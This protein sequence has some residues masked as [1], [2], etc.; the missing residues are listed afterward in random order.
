MLKKLISYQNKT[1]IGAAF[2]LA[3]ASLLSRAFGLIR[4]RLLAGTFGASA[5][6]DI[7]Y[8]AFRLPDL[9]YNI[10]I[11]GA[12]SVSF[13]PLF[14][15]YFI[16]NKEAAWKYTVNLFNILFIALVGVSLILILFSTP[17][18]RLIA[19]GFSGDAFVTTVALSRVMFL[20]PL[21]LGLSA[22]AGGVLHYFKRFLIYSLA[23]ILYNIG[24]II[25]I[26]IFFPFFGL[27]GLAWG[28]VLG[29]LLHLLIQL[30][31]VRSCGFSWTSFI[32]F[33]DASIWK[34]FSM[35][36]PRTI[37]TASSQI[38]FWF[39]TAIA[40]LL[41]SGSIAIFNFAY[42]LSYIP[43]GIFGITLAMATFPELAKSEARQDREQFLYNVSYGL[44]T[45]FFLTF[46]I[47][48]MFYILRAHIVR[49]VLGV[50][51]FGWVDTRLT[52]AVLGILA[53]SVFAQSIIPFLARSFFALKDTK[54]PTI[55]TVIFVVLNIVLTFFFVGMFSGDG[56]FIAD[57]LR[58]E[59]LPDIRILGPALGFSI[60]NIVQCVLLLW[61]LFQRVMLPKQ[62]LIQSAWRVL[63]GTVVALPVTYISL[64]GAANFLSTDTFFGIALQALI[65]FVMGGSI[66]CFVMITLRS[67]EIVSLYNIF[68]SRLPFKV[69]IVSQQENG[70][71]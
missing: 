40:S 56:R 64:Y 55:L 37:S 32:D 54:T 19:P 42:N 12:V 8:A 1:T 4:D 68:R 7:Y 5:E 24:I 47:G 66:Y 61:L 51:A 45:I 3:L 63:I 35:I 10:L 17:L 29:A 50:G 70:R 15:D 6:L 31:S 52:A 22:I 16:N 62:E 44:R 38:N 49:I 39:I 58:I 14:A 57:F 26:T 59:D 48:F 41:A 43:I 30:I 60:A 69:P 25:G 27:Y 23:P 71:F 46:P 2:I 36:A 18:I 65:A 34:T 53:L 11:V 33:K 21:L 28:V 67:P 13:I 20:S 9:I